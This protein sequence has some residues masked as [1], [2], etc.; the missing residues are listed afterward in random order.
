M[1]C[2]GGNFSCVLVFPREL[3]RRTAG[4]PGLATADLLDVGYGVWAGKVQ[5]DPQTQG[6]PQWVQAQKDSVQEEG[7][8]GETVLERGCPAAGSAQNAASARG[9]EKSSLRAKQA[10]EGYAWEHLA[11]HLCGSQSSKQRGKSHCYGAEEAPRGHLR[12]AE[13]L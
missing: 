2:L 6:T 4:V 8:S 7:G 10:H 5:P 11:E 9:E 3:A 13:R 1:V 12:P